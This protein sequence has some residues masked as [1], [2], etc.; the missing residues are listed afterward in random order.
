M[1]WQLGLTARII[2]AFVCFAATLLAGVGTLSYN[3]GRASLRA[4]ALSEL[5][6]TAIQKSTAL[7]NWVLERSSDLTELTNVPGLRDDMAALAAA[8]PR[9]PAARAAHNRIVQNLRPHVVSD[10]S[11]YRELFVLEPNG[12]RVLASTDARQEGKSRKGQPY[13]ENGKADLFIQNP[14]RPNNVQG[15]VMTMAAPIRAAGGRAQGVLVAQ[16]NLADMSALIQ[17][18]TGLRRTDDAYLV[19]PAHQFVTQ[20]RFLAHLAVLK[21]PFPTEATKRCLAGNSGILLG[22][23]YH[24]RSALIVYR[25]LPQRKMGLIVRMEQAEAFAPVRAFGEMILFSSVLAL[26]AASVLALGL[27]RT[28]T[29]PV[30]VLQD[31]VARFGRGEE[32]VRLPETSGDE[33]GLLAREFNTMA[34]A[35]SEKETLLRANAAHLEERVE[36]RTA[37]WAESNTA[38]ESEVR[39]RQRAQATLQESEERLRALY[40]TTSKMELPFAEKMDRLLALGCREFGVE[41]GILARIEGERFEV[42]HARSTDDA[43]AP[44]LV[45]AVCDTFC[46]EAVRSEEPLAFEHAGASTWK[47]HPAYAAFKTEAYLGTKVWTADA[48][49]GTLCFASK[50]PRAQPFTAADKEFVRLMAQW[51]GGEIARRH[52]EDALNEATKAAEVARAQAESANRAKSEFLANMSHEIR[53]PMNGVLGPVGLLLDSNLTPPQREMTE[54]VR[55]SGEALLA[56]IND[57]LDLSKIEVGKLTIEPIAFDLLLTVEEATGMMAARA[58]E[59]GLDLIVRYAPDVP[60]RVVGDPGRIRQVLANLTSNALKF[61]H[62]GHVLINIE[63]AAQEPPGEENG[64]AALRFSVTDTGIGIPDD[65]IA[66]VFGRFN[67]ADTSTTRRYGGTGLGL[68]ICQQLTELMGGQ[69]GVSS[70]PGE[71]STFWFTLHLPRQADRSGAAAPA[72]TEADVSGVRVL[73]VDDNAVNRRVLHEQLIGWRMRPDDTSSAEEA[74][75]ALHAA[76]AAG[77]PFGIAILDHQMP[78]TDGEMLGQTIKADL[79]LRETPLVMLTSLGHKGDAARLK[80]AGFAA[81]LTKPA[82]QSELLATLV[83]V[84]TAHAAPGE[85][86]AELVTRHSLAE[87]ARGGGASAPAAAA[88][89]DSSHI[90]AVNRPRWDGTRVLLAEDNTVNQKVATMMLESLGC[91]I[92]IAA[93][94]KEA[95]RM[96]D[97]ASYDLVFMDCE[98]PEM[99]G[100]EATALIRGRVDDKAR[101]PIIAVTAQA[102]QGDRE[103]CLERGMDDYI[104]KPVQTKAFAAALE[105]WASRPDAPEVGTDADA[106]DAPALDAAKFAQLCELAEA[107]GPGLLEE[108]FAAFQSDGTERIAAL[109]RAAASEGNGSGDAAAASLRKAA[110]AL[111]GA[112]ANVGARVVA[113]VSQQIEALGAAGSTAGADAL[114]DALEREFGRV[115]TEIEARRVVAGAA[116]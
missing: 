59:K 45:C 92:A 17:Q 105:R 24:H 110:H 33:L 76:R 9:S 4:A 103:R 74:L 39:E 53:T 99:D 80:A 107:S 38:L 116:K 87:A 6:S 18:R 22:S 91:R 104:S 21:E 46:D 102:T 31:R 35:L 54:I 11:V 57:I 36:E 60:R 48:V 69:I 79:A 90:V 97:E 72:L 20:P 13:F 37:R 93:N 84:W 27:A 2:L 26:L 16:L 64:A 56:I 86:A 28:I 34:G 43:L 108:I 70:V 58:Q 23:D 65:K 73:I 75:A 15:P 98:M 115:Q 82:R 81:Y 29:Q 63:N 88:K 12:G 106:A 55:A 109:R 83:N 114:I 111:K 61:T 14:Y 19:N 10:G 95:V 85:H 68:A 67:Q 49:C 50:Q 25:W 5:L 8:A 62:Q 78:D 100:F 96:L 66:H 1:K 47:E 44:G 41:T 112:S 71:G 113:D 52:A 42:L 77:D 89:E 101:L 94:G 7:D 32:E 40:D 51:I 30:R 3:S